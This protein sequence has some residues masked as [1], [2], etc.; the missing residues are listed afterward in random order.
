M[1][2]IK[3]TFSVLHVSLNVLRDGDV[4][5]L[6]P[7]YTGFLVS[8]FLDV[9]KFAWLRML[10]YGPKL[11]LLKKYTFRSEIKKIR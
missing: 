4:C 9:S 6:G 8:T 3:T 5:S 10:M 7:P 1:T 11:A 2:A